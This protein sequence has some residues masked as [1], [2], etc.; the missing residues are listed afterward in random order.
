MCFISLYSV[1]NTL[2]E[3]KYLYISK[4]FNL[5]TFLLVFK[6]V[7][8]LQCILK[9]LF[10]SFKKINCLKLAD[11]WFQKF[12]KPCMKFCHSPFV[13]LYPQHAQSLFFL[14]IYL[15]GRNKIG[16]DLQIGKDKEFEAQHRYAISNCNPFLPNVFLCFWGDQ[17]GTFGRKG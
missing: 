12:I 13:Y 5:Y 1:L 2:S 17:K 15:P 8:R 14:T 7:E 4:T 16:K 11:Q 10:S 6:I 3:Y 9:K